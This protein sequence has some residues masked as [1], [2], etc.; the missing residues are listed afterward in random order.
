MTPKD[1]VPV[2]WLANASPGDPVFDVLMVL[3][4]I[5]LAVVAVVGRTTA[6]TGLVGLYVAAFVVYVV[7]NGID[8]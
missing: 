3:G 1:A 4:P 5:L 2:A 7:Y 8:K 6:T